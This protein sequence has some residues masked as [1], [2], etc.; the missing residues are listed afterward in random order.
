MEDLN[1]KNINIMNKKE[2]VDYLNN[3]LVR[4]DINDTDVN[5]CIHFNKKYLKSTKDSN[6]LKSLINRH[7]HVF[8]DWLFKAIT[9]VVNKENIKTTTEGSIM[10][11]FMVGERIT[12]Y[13]E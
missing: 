3:R 11:G 1:G 7:P 9:I 8:N 10:Q 6:T 4:K 12:S 13:S 5:F 2:V